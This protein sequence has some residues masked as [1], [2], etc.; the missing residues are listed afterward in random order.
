MTLDSIGGPA[1][2]WLIAALALGIA[3]LIVPGVFLVFLAIAAAI[4]GAATLAL[5]DLPAAAQLGSFAVWSAVA[6]MIGRRWYVDYSPA[7]A[8][9]LLNRRTSRMVGQIVTVEVP[10]RNGQGRVIVGDG[11]WP[12]RGPDAE[13]GERLHVTRV[14]GGV[15]EVE[16]LDD[17]SIGTG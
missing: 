10:L 5:P 1:G 3:E 7:S 2:A 13:A 14:E 17:A 6:V 16:K 15:V 9:P 11:T 12:A 4:T 8:D